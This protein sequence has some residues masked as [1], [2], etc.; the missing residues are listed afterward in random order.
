MGLGTKTSRV[1]LLA[2]AAVVALLGVPGA[3][4]AAEG[5]P[6]LNFAN[7]LTLAQAG[8]LFVIFLVLYLA[9][10]HW[11][12]PQVA[13]VVEARAASIRADLDVAQQSKLTA[14]AAVAE[15]HEVTRK[16]HAEAQ[17]RI[18]GE[19]ATAKQ[20]AAARAVEANLA[21]DAKLAEAEARIA[22]SRNAAMG[23]LRQVAAETT[24]AVVQRLLGTAPEAWQLD[25]AV[26]TAL[27]SRK[28]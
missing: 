15:L 2:G 17:A 18:A 24:S 9:V 25:Q 3:A 1:R 10:K 4:H 7:P 20:E 5:M 26:G 14:D 16:A 11:G 6:Q 28:A 22:A 13:Q 27:A 8:W 19:V 21:L 12:L 23:A